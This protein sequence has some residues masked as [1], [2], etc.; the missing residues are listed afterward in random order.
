MILITSMEKTP[1]VEMLFNNVCDFRIPSG[2][3]YIFDFMID[4]ISDER[5]GLKDNYILWSTEYNFNLEKK[6]KLSENH[7]AYVKAGKMAW[8][9][10]NQTK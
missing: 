9:F 1:V 3:F 7:T 2:F 4:F 8:R 10:C 5:Y 6:V